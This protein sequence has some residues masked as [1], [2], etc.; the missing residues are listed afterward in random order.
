[1]R[2]TNVV[3][4]LTIAAVA[5][6]AGG[7]CSS[8]RR[9]SS[10]ST[11]AAPTGNSAASAAKTAA[12]AAA[13]FGT[14]PSP[15]G[16]GN[17]KG[18]T[19]QGVTDTSIHIG[20]GDD[21]GFSGSPGLNQ[22]V[23]DAVKAMIKWCN[24]QGGI[25]GRQVVGDFYDAA[26]SQ[27]ITVTQQA[28]KAD[29]MLVG[30]GW[31]LDEGAEGTRVACNLAAV[32]AFTS[33]PD[34]ANG[35]EMYQAV[36][37]PVDYLPASSFYEMAQLFPDAIKKFDFLHTT[38]ALAT[39]VAYAKDAQPAAA[40]GWVNDN[41]GVTINYN[42]EPDYKPFA[43]KFVSCGVKSIYTSLPPS[44]ELFGMLTANDQLG[45]K[46]I[47][48]MDTSAY[49]TELA[50][51]NTSGAGNNIY[52]RVAFVPLEEASQVPAV[53]QYLN[54][55]NPVGGKV[56]QLGEQAASS[57]L[58]W[59][60]EA[61][62]CGSNLTRQCMINNLSKVHNWTGGG[63]HAPADPGGNLPPQCGMLLKLTGTTWSQFYPKTAGQFDCDSKYLFHTSPA[64]WRTTL[65]AN[66]M[67]TKFLSSNV[68]TPQS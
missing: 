3:R 52:V 12:P 10:S 61:K 58:L 21:R 5:A 6:L 15:C 53:Q 66:R 16:Q 47:Y 24:D 9:G 1:V 23:G 49:T 13:M 67:S 57:F 2:Q 55:V 19:E 43:Q 51:W 35:P 36:P 11:T 17:A 63:L 56:S 62:A 4:L 27:V 38:L 48:S 25:L 68:I 34:F 54:I 37:N 14:L 60:T 41:C 45:L 40:A 65:D 32:P 59:A 8:A 33:G 7:A 31:G 28:C 18:A 39:E 44:P 22:A 20:Y 29:F 50:Q 64:A 26:I 46:P 30:E 42:G